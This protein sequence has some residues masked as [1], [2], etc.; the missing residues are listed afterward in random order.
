MLRYLLSMIFYQPSSDF[1]IVLKRLSQLVL[2]RASAFG[3]SCKTASRFWTR[4]CF[5]SCSRSFLVIK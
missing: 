3:V 1:S 5:L 2:P 4:F